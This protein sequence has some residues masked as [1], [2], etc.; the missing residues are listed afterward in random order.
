[1]PSGSRKHAR[2]A[3]ICFGTGSVSAKMKGAGRTRRLDNAGEG[4]FAEQLSR[5]LRHFSSQNK[6]KNA[7]RSRKNSGFPT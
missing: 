3:I 2:R 6:A 7:G 5:L 4:P 1:M